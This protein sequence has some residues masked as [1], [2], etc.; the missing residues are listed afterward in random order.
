MEI[1]ATDQADESCAL[2]SKASDHVTEK[3]ETSEEPLA[4]TQAATQVTSESGSG[5]TH[6]PPPPSGIRAKGWRIT[7]IKPSE[8]MWGWDVKQ[9]QFL[10]DT[11]DELMPLPPLG[12]ATVSSGTVEVE[13]W[14]PENAFRYDIDAKWGGRKD[15]S[16]SFYIGVHCPTAV[17]LGEVRLQQEPHPS[18]PPVDQVKIEF[19]MDGFGGSTQWHKFCE[20][21]ISQNSLEPIWFLGILYYV[22]A[23]HMCNKNWCAGPYMQHDTY[24]EVDHAKGPSLADAPEGC[25]VITSDTRMARNP[26]TGAIY[27]LV[28][29]S[30][31][32]D[33][34]TEWMSGHVHV[35]LNGC[36]AHNHDGEMWCYVVGGRNCWQARKSARFPGAFFISGCTPSTQSTPKQ[37]LGRPLTLNGK[38]LLA[39]ATAT[40]EVKDLADG[41]G[42]PA[43]NL[44]HPMLSAVSGRAAHMPQELLEEALRGFG[45]GNPFPEATGTLA[46]ESQLPHMLA[47]AQAELASAGPEERE[48]WKEAG[49]AEHASVGSFAKLCLELL[50]AGAP[51]RLLRRAIKAQEEELVHAHLSLGLLRGANHELQSPSV[52]KSLRG[53]LANATQA[54]GH[55]GFAIERLDLPEHSF[56]VRRDFVAL[57]NAAIEEGLIGEG[58]AALRL[59]QRSLETLHG[60]SEGKLDG[61]EV[62][63]EGRRALAKI[64]WAIANDEARHA[65]LAMETI[66]WLSG[67][68]SRPQAQ[69]PKVQI[70]Q[71]TVVVQEVA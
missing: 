70:S 49:L 38:T 55:G 50:V 36:A 52:F 10:T 28:P 67:R 30:S 12:C 3:L 35:G 71:G 14:E 41:W 15:A 58:R 29:F 22:E 48:H 57:R 34:T 46:M 66:E 37:V 64:V 25:G 11:G 8:A 16:G 33:C 62:L 2:Q 61:R 39:A 51:P 1:P 32:C 69:L 31:P 18:S 26:E 47:V 24:V 27:A 45:A 56:E 44:G 65:A 68:D 13:G 63:S 40:R 21:S 54:D 17:K 5:A 43:S 19:T 59:F 20:V 23:C 7:A 6:S 9:V 53:D 42:F 60:Q 4:A